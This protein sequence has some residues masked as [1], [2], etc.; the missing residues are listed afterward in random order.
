MTPPPGDARN[1]D[2]FRVLFEHSSDAHVIYDDTGRVLDCN[3]AAVQL[4]KATDK[5]KEIDALVRLSGLHRF[6]WMLRRL[7][8]LIGFPHRTLPNVLKK[9]GHPGQA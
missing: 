2:R 6:E 7:G 5:A 8:R 9:L 4:L 3:D 1:G